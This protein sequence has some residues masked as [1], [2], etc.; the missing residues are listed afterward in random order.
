[1]AT[2]TWNNVFVFV[3]RF[4]D[5]YCGCLI[6]HLCYALTY[7]T[8]KK[9]HFKYMQHNL[10]LC[11]KYTLASKVMNAQTFQMFAKQNLEIDAI[12][13]M[14]VLLLFFLAKLP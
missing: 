6:K 1:M 5:V 14:Y 13:L 7:L 11:H 3:M 12:V 10:K 8:N 9:K 2:L 4:D